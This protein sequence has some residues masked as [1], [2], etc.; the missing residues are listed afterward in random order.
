[1]DCGFFMEPWIIL[2]RYIFSS[3]FDTKMYLCVSHYS[4]V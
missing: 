3:F 4:F 1:M 2:K